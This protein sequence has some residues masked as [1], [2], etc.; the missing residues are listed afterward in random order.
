[1]K[2]ILLP[3]LVL[4]AALATSPDRPA[5]QAATRRPGPL[6]R[7]H[8]IP[9]KYGGG[10]CHIRVPHVHVYEAPNASA[11][12]ASTATTLY[13]VGDPSPTAGTARSY[14]YYGP[15]PVRVDAVVGDG[16]EDTE[17]CYI[18]GPHYHIYAPPAVVSADF[19]LKDGAYWYVGD[20]A[21]GLRRAR[22]R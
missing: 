10:Y 19:E 11:T 20:S 1:M 2:R 6:R 5:G 8:P 15:H 18:K 9:K 16:D 13:Y 14:A 22:R 21:R 12:T 7:A 4:V 17:Y 3:L